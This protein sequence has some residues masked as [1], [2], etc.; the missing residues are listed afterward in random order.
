MTQQNET[1]T[2]FL[3]NWSTIKMAMKWIMK[4][5]IDNVLC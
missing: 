3:E 5:K 4:D 2:S 1:A